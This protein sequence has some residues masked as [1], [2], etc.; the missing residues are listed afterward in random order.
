MFLLLNLGILLSLLASC[1]SGPIKGGGE[2]K[3]DCS[4]AGKMKSL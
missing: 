3:L 4:V 1:L 2:I